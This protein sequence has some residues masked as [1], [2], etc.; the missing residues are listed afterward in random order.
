LRHGVRRDGKALLPFM[1][2]ANLS[3][4]DL[5][6]LI[7]FLRAQAPVDHPVETRS[8]NLL[9]RAVLA[10]LIKPEG[11]SGPVPPSVPAAATPA[12]G[13]Y[14][15]HHVA[16]CV[17]CHTR[18]DLRTGA[19][20][21]A[22]F[23]GG[24]SFPSEKDPHVTFVTPN[25]TFARTGRIT[26]WTEELFIARLRTGQGADGSPMPWSAFARM[27]QDDLRAVY[28]YL[29]SLAPVENDTGESVRTEIVAMTHAKTR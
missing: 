3:D 22:P 8:L 1:P 20:V 13:K 7:S 6:A 10:L 2:F 4:D 26:G 18:R 23:A 29:Q 17:G 16:N 9:G 15:A 27:S 19:Y 11:P 14:L 24:L 21:G 28:R 5:T 25:L 12:Y